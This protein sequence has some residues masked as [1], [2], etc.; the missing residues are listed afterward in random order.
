MRP[1]TASAQTPT[2]TARQLWLTGDQDPCC[3]IPSADG[4][5]IAYT[6]WST[7]DLGVRDLIS[8]TSRRLTSSTRASG[9][10]AEPVKAISPD[11]RFIAY[12]W[13][14]PKEKSV[15]LRVIPAAGGTAR[16]VYRSTSE[17]LLPHDWTA[18][19]RQLLVM[20]RL[21]DS[22]WQI[23][24]V[25]VD[26]GAVRAIKSL[27]WQSNT[28]AHLSPDGRFI[29]YDGPVDG[30]SPARD[31]FVL[32][33]SGSSEIRLVENPA[34][35]TNPVWSPDGTRIL[36]VSNRTGTPS[37]WAAPVL[38]GKPSGPATL[39]QADFADKGP[40]G[41]TR[42][43]SLYYTS[44]GN[45]GENVYV[46]E[47][48]S[49]MRVTQAP[50]V[51]T[52]R[53]INSNLGPGV[54]PD[55]ERLAYLSNR[56]G[57]GR[58]LVVRTLKTGEERDMGRGANP[59]NSAYGPMWFPGGDSVLMYAREPQRPGYTFSRVHLA[60]GKWE[61]LLHI[62][63]LGGYALSPDGKSIYYSGVEPD[64]SSEMMQ[65]VRFDI[66]TKRETV[67]RRGISAL[68][69][70]VS[71]DSQQVAYL[72]S[73]LGPHGDG[74]SLEILPAAGGEA[75]V[76]YSDSPWAFPANSNGLGWS[77]DGRS[78]LFVRGG[79]SENDESVLW[80]VPI[81]GGQAEQIGISRKGRI[82][83]PQMHPNGKQIYFGASEP[84]PGELWALENFLPA[85]KGK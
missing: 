5:Y 84:A 4:R 67:L 44:R 8:G 45:G 65:L 39:I 20:H 47:M 11:G 28:N 30:K 16:T 52:E 21:P 64:S 58:V 26:D 2:P 46:A 57:Q 69:V 33:T 85:V 10:F 25:S 29:A 76:V 49:A 73:G 75:R 36:F 19:G 83:S 79:S 38:N 12:A 40:L 6:D 18:D 59:N 32:A 27:G 68:S 3:T 14:M 53:F 23:A 80:R 71:P 56:P 77:A 66:E 37:L 34:N 17:Y 1:Q 13:T 62:A 72:V 24:M 9:D 61:P 22:T 78:L 60:D 50:R 63:R 54:S 7:G 15:E 48:D 35:D 74:S 70:S 55:G 31:I 41:F 42:S 43:G 51:A 81:S 82:K